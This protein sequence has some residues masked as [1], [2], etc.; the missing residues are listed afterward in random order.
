MKD[1]Y[2]RFWLVPTTD[3]LDE[4]SSLITKFTSEKVFSEVKFHFSFNLRLRRRISQVDCYTATY[5]IL[6]LFYRTFSFATFKRCFVCSSSRLS[7]TNYDNFT[8]LYCSALNIQTVLLLHTYKNRLFY[9]WRYWHW[10]V[11]YH[12]TQTRLLKKD[13]WT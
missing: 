11:L 5:C 3:C 10:T 7:H 9:L 13:D 6:S 4:V 8:P 2:E 12:A 1:H